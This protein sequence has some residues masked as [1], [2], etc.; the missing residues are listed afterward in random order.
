MS[1]AMNSSKFFAPS[2]VLSTFK[3]VRRHYTYISVQRSEAV[4]NVSKL[5]EY[6]LLAGKYIDSYDVHGN[7]FKILEYFN[8]TLHTFK[9]NLIV[10]SIA[11]RR[12]IF[13]QFILLWDAR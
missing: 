10:S 12:Q 4:Y 8:G 9:D 6:L 3:I 2:Y 7:Y 13:A 11:V 5:I 1:I